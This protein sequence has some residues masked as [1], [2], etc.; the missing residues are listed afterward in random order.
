MKSLAFIILLFLFSQIVF[1]QG[2]DLAIKAY[3]DA[4][5]AFDNG[6]YEDALSNLNIAETML[7]KTNPK[8]QELKRKS[9][10]LLAFL[11]S[12]KNFESY[13]SYVNDLNTKKSSLANNAVIEKNNFSKEKVL[14]LE[15]KKNSLINPIEKITL[16]QSFSTI[17]KQLYNLIDF[18]NPIEENH[19]IHYIRKA[20][21]TE[22]EIGLYE[23]SVDKNND[24]I[25]KITAIFKSFTFEEFQKQ[26]MSKFYNEKFSK[27]GQNDISSENNVSKI[28][29][30]DYNIA[31]TRAKIDNSTSY[32]IS[33]YTP[34]KL[35]Y[36][37][38][39]SSNSMYFYMEGYE[40]K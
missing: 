38:L 3:K 32:F 35:K 28:K 13:S 17:Q 6:N 5:L 16:G 8:I 19:F 9:Y 15:N 36:K 22:T 2:T 26:N 1:A 11:D 7:K 4:E 37:D 27:F 40:I 14:F 18:E 30:K 33:L 20:S 34:T 29:K 24:R 31:I 10:K 21:S 12:A 23:I 25:V 39:T